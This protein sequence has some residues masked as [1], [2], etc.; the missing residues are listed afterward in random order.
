MET[1]LVVIGMVLAMVGFFL[2]TVLAE[3]VQD[4]SMLRKEEKREREQL[5]RRGIEPKCGHCGSRNVQ[6]ATQYI[7]LFGETTVHPHENHWLCADCKAVSEISVS[8]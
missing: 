1:A 6:L 7:S 8:V 5:T 3:K 4:R 2:L